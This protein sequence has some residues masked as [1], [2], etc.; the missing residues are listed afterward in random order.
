MDITPNEFLELLKECEQKCDVLRLYNQNHPL[1]R[2]SDINLSQDQYNQRNRQIVRE[3]NSNLKNVKRDLTFEELFD[4]FIKFRADLMA[5]IV[6]E[7]VSFK[8]PTT[9]K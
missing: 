7:H 4:A 8:A 1:L 6:I 3:Y 5:A 9:Q 2:F